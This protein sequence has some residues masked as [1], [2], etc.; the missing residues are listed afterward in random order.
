MPDPAAFGEGRDE[1]VCQ[2]EIVRLNKI[3]KVLMDRAERS[4]NTQGSEF[5]LFQTT[6]MLEDQVRQRTEELATA[7]RE[8]ETIND[9]LRQSEAKFRGLVSQSLAGISII[10]DARF[11]YANSKFAEIFGYT[12][13]EILHA[14]VIDTVAHSDRQ[15]VASQLSRRLRGEVDR[16]D[17]VFRGLR[18]NRSEI[19][20]ECHS[21]VMDIGGKPAIISLVV[22][23]TE[24]IRTEREVRALQDQLREQAIHDSLTGLY[25]RQS[26]KEFFDRELSLAERHHRTISTVMGD[27]DHFKAVND[28]YGHLAG[29][30]V[31]R[32]FG[33]LL[34]RSYRASDIHCRYGGEEFLILLPDMPELV[35]YKRTERLRAM[36]EKTPIPFGTSVIRVTAS[37]G[38]ATFPQDGRNRDALIGAADT[39]LYAAKDAGRNQVKR[40]SES[41]AT[42]VQPATSQ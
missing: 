19:D 6:V 8:I 39:A 7:L 38:I 11:S 24:R 10:E 18:K 42:R 27:L 2:A 5:S 37:F 23:V 13:E 32:V 14:S 34:R 30:E 1:S 36:I 12:P 28:T 35:A 40:Y 17:Y 41:I 15:L 4:T 29:D 33:D 3:I 20:V 21:S 31:L 25:N 16:V 9:A 22:D 26:L